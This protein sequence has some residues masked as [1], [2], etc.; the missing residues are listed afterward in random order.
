[1]A[2]FASPL[3]ALAARRAWGLFHRGIRAFYREVSLL[4]RD[5]AAFRD[6]HR[7]GTN[8]DHGWKPGSSAG[9]SAFTEGGVG[10]GGG[11]GSTDFA[12]RKTQA[13]AAKDELTAG[14][15]TKQKMR[16][17]HC[18]NYKKKTFAA[19]HSHLSTRVTVCGSACV[20]QTVRARA[21]V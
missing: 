4:L 5:S 1:V 19:G 8:R 12:D 21:C 16:T 9:R 20:W 3:Q 17:L 18:L 13:F 6:P 7:A 11:G 15:Q 2:S 14:F 10:E